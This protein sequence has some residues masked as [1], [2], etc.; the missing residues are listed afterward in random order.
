MI[1]ITA[2]RKQLSHTAEQSSGSNVRINI[3]LHF[4]KIMSAQRFFI[5][6]ATMKQKFAQ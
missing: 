1:H 3:S 5:S 4:G 2:E 6:L